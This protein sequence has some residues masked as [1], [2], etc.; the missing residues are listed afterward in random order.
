M[1]KQAYESD[2]GQNNSIP[3]LARGTLQSQTDVG[4]SAAVIFFDIGTAPDA[5]TG[6]RIPMA[7]DI[8]MFWKCAPGDKVATHD[9]S[10]GG[11]FTNAVGSTTTVVYLYYDSTAGTSY[12]LECA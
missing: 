1:T 8:G 7:P 12:L 10:A 6:N 4:A 9:G 11:S 5:S 3:V 2:P